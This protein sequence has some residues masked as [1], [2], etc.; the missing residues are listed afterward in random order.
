MRNVDADAF[1]AGERDVLTTLVENDPAGFSA[2]MKSRAL[3]PWLREQISAAD[4]RALGLPWQ[5]VLAVKVKWSDLSNGAPELAD[6]YDIWAQGHKTTT[7]VL[8][9]L[10]GAGDGA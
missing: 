6:L 1:D 5:M 2:A 4:A 8:A 3:M 9:R 10:S 7:D